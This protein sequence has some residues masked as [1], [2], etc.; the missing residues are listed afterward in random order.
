MTAIDWH[1]LRAAAVLGSARRPLRPTI[2]AGV[3][4]PDGDTVERSM[5][6]AAALLGVQRRSGARA[7][8]VGGPSEPAPVDDRSEAST[9]ATQ[10]LELVLAG[11]VVRAADS[12]P[13]VE[14]W[15]TACAAAG[16][17]VPDRSL[18]D[19]LQ[20][21]QSSAALRPLVLGVLGERGRWLARRHPAWREWASLDDEIPTHER[22]AAMSTKERTAALRSVRA[23][24]PAAAR[25][26]VAST[27]VDDRAA[28]RSAAIGAFDVGLGP[29]DEPFLEHA[30]DDGSKSVRDAAKSALDRLPDS[31]RGRRLA[32]ALAPL[33]SVH[34]LPTRRRVELASLPAEADTAALER[35]LMV[36]NGVTV[37][38]SLVVHAP[39]PVWERSTGRTPTDL[40][41][42][43]TEPPGLRD[44]WALAAAAQQDTAWAI[45]VADVTGNTAPLAQCV[46]PWSPEDT[47][48]VLS[49]A[50]RDRSPES[51]VASLAE[52][53]AR[54][55]HPSVVPV[56]EEWL[57]SLGGSPVALVNQ[58][59]RLIK[60]LSTRTAVTEAFR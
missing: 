15:F 55:A 2:A 14:H 44:L 30:L 31:D 1:D 50:A 18:V 45:A 48:R 9:A 34:G 41:A 17:R 49:I 27:W 8:A 3:V 13:I 53:L 52:S 42:M 58:L 29:D 46:G 23:V 22:F 4:V 11:N 33:I 28:D 57:G 24:D 43:T 5:L 25:A 19:V 32:A 6:T 60:I 47:R 51:R 37:L 36:G 56:L 20:R 39:L 54:C 7:V 59:R 35:D 40:L 16:R 38:R 26:L 10:L 21:A 12:M